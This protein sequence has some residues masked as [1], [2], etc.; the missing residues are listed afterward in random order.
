MNG[1]RRLA[2]AAAVIAVLASLGYLRDPP[3]L[4]AVVSGLSSW[5]VD[6]GGV[7]YRWATP[8]ASFF[9]PAGAGAIEIPLRA[10]DA[11]AEWPTVATIAIDDR[12][13]D[14][15]LLGDASWHR[16]VLR[17]PPRAGRRVRRVDI[18]LDRAA[19]QER[20]AQVGEVVVR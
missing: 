2:A 10:A 19:D 12:P 18:R 13:A 4:I 17:L 3:W 7:R 11:T 5:R 20:A 16:A 15:V 8:H 6:A 14:R 1:R 9:V